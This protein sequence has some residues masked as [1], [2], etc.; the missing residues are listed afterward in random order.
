M[1][2]Q[3]PKAILLV[4]DSKDAICASFTKTEITMGDYSQNKDTI[5][6]EDLTK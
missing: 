2:Y 1:K 4:L 5:T 3:D 6:F